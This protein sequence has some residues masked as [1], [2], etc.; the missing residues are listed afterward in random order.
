MLVTR[1]RR[2]G[3]HPCKIAWIQAP[4]IGEFLKR[5]NSGVRVMRTS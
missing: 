5:S 2:R 4:N 3:A 1:I